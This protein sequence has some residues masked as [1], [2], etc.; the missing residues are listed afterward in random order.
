MVPIEASR[1]VARI[2]ILTLRMRWR[3]RNRR[4][5]CIWC[6][7]ER[8]RTV[9]WPP[10]ESG[11]NPRNDGKPFQPFFQHVVE[12]RRR[13]ALHHDGCTCPR[14]TGVARLPRRALASSRTGCRLLASPAR[15]RTREKLGRE[16][17]T[18][19]SPRGQDGRKKNANP[20]KNYLFTRNCLPRAIQAGRGRPIRLRQR[21]GSAPRGARANDGILKIND[22]AN[23]Q[24]GIRNPVRVTL[25]RH[26]FV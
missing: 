14:T 22:N 8:R 12:R 23:Y 24:R 26:A 25:L 16:T 19:S 4:P 2:R 11:Y 20:S 7:L 6:S 9:R 15:A 18:R 13:D 17:G 3:V 1:S 21:R 10:S 5:A